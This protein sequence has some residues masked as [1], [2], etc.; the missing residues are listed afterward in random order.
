MNAKILLQ[1]F[2]HRTNSPVAENLNEPLK[3][4]DNHLMIQTINEMVTLQE[5]NMTIKAF[6]SEVW[7]P[8]NMK[9]KK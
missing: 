2:K 7:L 6:W 5:S 8:A 4:M 1:V 3:L 9:W